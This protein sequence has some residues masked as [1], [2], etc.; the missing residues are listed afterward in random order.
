MHAAELEEHSIMGALKEDVSSKGENSGQNI[1]PIGLR[2]VFCF[3]FFLFLL[4]IDRAFLL[5]L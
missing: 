4:K 5:I 2:I 3:F 1:F